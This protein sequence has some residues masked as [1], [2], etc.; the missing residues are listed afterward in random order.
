MRI[1]RTVAKEIYDFTCEEIKEIT[2][3]ICKT[4]YE[5]TDSEVER[6]YVGV[7]YF[8]QRFIKCPFCKSKNLVS[9]DV[10]YRRI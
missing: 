1:I 6:D 5:Y 9:F 4:L 3:P 8:P 10:Y 7:Y 2:C